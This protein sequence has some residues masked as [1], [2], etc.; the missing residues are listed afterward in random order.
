MADSWN[1][2]GIK[3]EAIHLGFLKKNSEGKHKILISICWWFFASILCQLRWR[4]NPVIQEGSRLER[5]DW[6]TQGGGGGGRRGTR[7]RSGPHPRQPLPQ[8]QTLSSGC[9]AASALFLAAPT[10]PGPASH[11]P[12][13]C[14]GLLCLASASPLSNPLLHRLQV[15]T[16]SPLGCCLVNPEEAQR[17]FLLPWV[18]FLPAPERPLSRLCCLFLVVP[19]LMI[20]GSSTSS[21]W[22]LFFPWGRAENS[23]SQIPSRTSNSQRQRSQQAGAKW[24]K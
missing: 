1:L 21:N 12:V 9:R 17:A 13:P 24:E 2:W 23:G 16:P 11:W 10:E 22:S 3:R 7:Q 6:Q 4:E 18:T 19:E 5:E 8:A 20:I 14:P 15:A